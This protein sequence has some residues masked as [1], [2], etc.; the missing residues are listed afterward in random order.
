MVAILD[1]IRKRP[2]EQPE[3]LTSEGKR[4]RTPEVTLE[5]IMSTKSMD[6]VHIDGDA[7]MVVQAP[8]HALA[9]VKA[10]DPDAKDLQMSVELGRS[11]SSYSRFLREE[12]NPELR[13]QQ[14]L[15]KYDRMRRSDAAIRSSLRTL[16]TP[17]LGAT[18]FVEPFDDK[19]QSKEIAKFIT[20]NFTQ[21]MTYPW[22]YVLWE[23][24]LMLDFGHWIHEK[25]WKF[26]EIDGQ[27]RII[28]SKMG[29]RHPLDVVDWILDANGGPV[30]VDMY[31]SPGTDDHR[32]IPIEKLAIFTFDGE[33]GDMRGI[34]VLRSAY[35]HWYFRENL[36]KID[37]IQKERHGIGIPI[38]KLP[39]NFTPAD[40]ILAHELGENLRTNEKAHI[41]LPPNWEIMFAKLEGLAVDPLASAQHHTEMIFQN[42]LA[43]AVFASATGDAETMME[44]FYKSTRY[45]ADLVRV[46]MNQYVIPYLVLGNWGIEDYPQLK[47]RKLG[48]TQEAR[49]ISFALRN[50]V[51]AGIIQVDDPLE[52]WSREIIDAPRADPSTRRQVPTPQNRG[53]VGPPRVGPPRQT[54]AAG[55]TRQ[56]TTPGAP[57]SGFDQSGG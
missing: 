29:S 28:L 53:T 17:V 37:A 24:L 30:A 38:I 18:W 34:S 23:A 47:V 20:R 11:T 25:V 12:Y 8:A 41:V 7:I 5:Q 9:P 14:G 32:R 44:L 36:Y 33:A 35:K 15:I 43:Q 39:P 10:A 46:V 4:A 6:L 13:D 26:K 1:R 21:Y 42:V 2:V 19:A 40:K 55:G 57:N 50:M 45:V 51:G 22:T 56:G 16:K 27:Q 31:N 54:P 3:I 48:D 49:T 52:E